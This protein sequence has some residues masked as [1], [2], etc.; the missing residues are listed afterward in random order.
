MEI[1]ADFK[2]YDCRP[3]VNNRAVDGWALSKYSF[4]AQKYHMTLSWRLSPHG[5]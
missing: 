4:L 3:D 5:H 2:D 1:K